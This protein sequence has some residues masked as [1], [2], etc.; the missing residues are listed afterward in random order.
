M[1]N[2]EDA[3]KIALNEDD[4]DWLYNISIFTEYKNVQII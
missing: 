2:S 3:F 1:V 4:Y